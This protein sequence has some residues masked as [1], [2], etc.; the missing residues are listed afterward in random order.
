MPKYSR[1]W[2]IIVVITHSPAGCW[3]DCK[4]CLVIEGGC[5]YDEF[6]L[7]CH[8]QLRNIDHS[9]HTVANSKTQKMV[10]ASIIV[11][12]TSLTVGGG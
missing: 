9:V 10:D 3:M 11:N 1:G 8:F 12:V 2:C 5:N 6:S 7:Q 4:P